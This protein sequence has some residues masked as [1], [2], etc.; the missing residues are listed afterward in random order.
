MKPCS[1]PLLT[2][3]T[4][5]AGEPGC[6]LWD[7]SAAALEAE[8]EQLYNVDDVEVA[9]YDMGPTTG[10]DYWGVR[11]LVTFTGDYVRG[12]V[13]QLQVTDLGADG[14]ADAG[15][16]DDARAAAPTPCARVVAPRRAP[17]R[18]LFGA[19]RGASDPRGARRGAP[20]P[21]RVF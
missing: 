14:C 8:L 9:R 7:G 19:R 2:Q 12:N 3:S 11:Y 10:D 1:V 4:T 17:R 21:R 18:A 5:A 13:P 20:P 15:D 16:A 6:L